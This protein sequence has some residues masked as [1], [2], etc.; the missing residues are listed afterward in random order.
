MYSIHAK[1]TFLEVS[2]RISVSVHFEGIYRIMT[3]KLKSKK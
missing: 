3:E 1:M 2:A